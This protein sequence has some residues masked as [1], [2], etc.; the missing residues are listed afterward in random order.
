MSESLD[1][2]LGEYFTK[3]GSRSE[4]DSNLAELFVSVLRYCPEAL[5]S[6]RRLD[7]ASA[8]SALR[9][10]GAVPRGQIAQM[11]GVD[12]ADLGQW[13]VGIRKSESVTSR[14]TEVLQS[15]LAAVSTSLTTTSP[16]V[17]F[18][19]PAHAYA[20][21]TVDVRDR[22]R[23]FAA[24][25][26][27]KLRAKVSGKHRILTT[28][29]CDWYRH[30]AH[31]ADRTLAMY[32]SIRGI[33]SITIPVPVDLIGEVALSCDYFL[34]RMGQGDSGWFDP[35]TNRICINADERP[36]RQ[37]YTFGHEIAHAM[38]HRVE[39]RGAVHRDPQATVDEER[40][41]LTWEVLQALTANDVIAAR[42]EE[43][44][45]R[46]KAHRETEANV[47]AAALIMPTKPLCE[48]I[49][50]GVDD[51]QELARQFGVSVPAIEWRLRYLDAC[52]GM[53]EA[54]P[55]SKGQGSLDF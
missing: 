17:P 11:A 20:R 46:R 49:Q 28:Q 1:K 16:S 53:P 15:V 47:F 21:S 24:V 27:A 13:E 39:L 5:T 4:R 8:V 18:P 38:M 51:V 2:I 42:S 26:L 22:N 54:K 45:L 33:G 9:R 25:Q 36:T 34:D 6:G 10:A 29:K 41:D 32:M 52:M 14:I 7:V 43:K 44:E 19:R 12:E 48:L 23:V 50:S 37:R 31:E 40:V 55:E 3:F 30:V 35:D